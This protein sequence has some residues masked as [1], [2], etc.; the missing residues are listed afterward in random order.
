MSTPLT[1][2]SLAVVALLLGRDWGHRRVTMFALLRPLIAIVI[3]P[4]FAPGWSGSGAGLAL[5]AGGLVLG[6]AI[7][8]LTFAFMRFSIDDHGQVWSDTGSTYAA[9]WIAFTAARLIFVYGTE[10]WFTRQIGTF[11]VGNHIAVDAFA[12]SIIFL[13]IAPII[14]NR[15][16]ILVRTRTLR[17]PAGAVPAADARP[18]S[19]QR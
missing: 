3:I 18:A 14:T 11:L 19:W 6:V 5:E 10:H 7:G 13:F 12:Y 2:I 8:L 17:A 9:I 4:F 1:I 15:L 16:A